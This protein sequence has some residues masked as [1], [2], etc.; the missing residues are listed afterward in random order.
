MKTE[1]R[2]EQ[3]L[4]GSAVL[5]ALEVK[6]ERM[7]YTEFARAVGCSHR[8]GNTLDLIAAVAEKCG[9]KVPLNRVYNKATGKPGSGMY[10]HQSVL[11]RRV[12]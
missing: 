9:D 12:S 7:T 3:A 5:R 2:L 6:D 11:I 1:R 10:G 4:R 8:K